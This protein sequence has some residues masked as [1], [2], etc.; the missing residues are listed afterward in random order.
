MEAIIALSTSGFI[1][2]YGAYA[3]LAAIPGLA[4]LSLLYFAQAREVRR[5]RDWAGRAPERDSEQHSTSGVHVAPTGARDPVSVVRRSP[6]PGAARPAGRPATPAASAASPPSPAA[7]AKPAGGAAAPAAATAAA[8]AGARP[9]AAGA[10]KAP[11][12]Q[13]QSE[14]EAK[15]D[16]EGP[17]AKPADAPAPVPAAAP[18]TNG[19]GDPSNVEKPVQR[20]AAAPVPVAPPAQAAPRP[21]AAAATAAGAAAARAFAGPAAP[22][23]PERRE[24]PAAP[25]PTAPP[26]RPSTPEASASRAVPLRTDRPRATA[27]SRGGRDPVPPRRDTSGGR[28][29]RAA[30]IAVAAV[31]VIILIVVIVAATSGGSSSKPKSPNTI[32]PSQQQANGA[33]TKPTKA[34]AVPRGDVKVAVLNGTT[35]AGLAAE[36]G[37]QVAA[38]GFAKGQVANA[39]DQQAQQTIVYYASGQKKAAQEVA[40]IIKVGDVQP[41]DPDTRAIA[42]NDAKVVVLVG[43]DKT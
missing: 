7:P 1:E 8:A 20:P 10:V 11:D 12:K 13:D 18:E 17:A 40:S 33:G 21:A 29:R 26:A 23:R 41:I 15:P 2:K 14:Q 4:V 35:Q 32:A 25:E 28:P 30:Y 37:N 31:L 42:G 22:P 3:G 19:P 39:A 43:A 34:A 27:P 9:A 24:Q 5:L 38:G 36:V 16:H 6:P